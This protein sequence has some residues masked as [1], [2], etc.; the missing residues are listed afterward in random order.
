MYSI[1]KLQGLSNVYTET[2]TMLKNKKMFKYM[3]N[4]ANST[5]CM[6]HKDKPNATFLLQKQLS[7]SKVN[8][9]DSNLLLVNG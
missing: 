4:K 3:Q 6:H 1:D 9:Y 2:F 8:K 5:E 7:L